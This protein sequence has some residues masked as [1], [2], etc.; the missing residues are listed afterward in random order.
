[1][2]SRSGT[3]AFRTWTS[4][5]TCSKCP[6]RRTGFPTPQVSLIFTYLRY[7]AQ[8]INLVCLAPEPE[9]PSGEPIAVTTP[10]ESVTT[11]AETASAV[12]KRR[13]AKGKAPATTSTEPAY[14]TRGAKRR[15][16]EDP[17]EDVDM[18]DVT[19]RKAD[20]PDV[21]YVLVDGPS[22]PR[23]TQR[24]R[25]DAG[26]VA[27][28]TVSCISHHSYHANMVIIFSGDVW[29]LPGQFTCGR[30]PAPIRVQTGHHSL[31]KLCPPAEEMRPRSCLGTAHLA[32]GRR[33]Q[34]PKHV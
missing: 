17:T 34:R 9:E 24:A 5:S 18:G 31:R 27:Y 12:A 8:L 20:L 19:P 25:K 4:Q 2:V 23:P 13:A 16:E 6:L 3:T 33:N 30:V 26:T 1:M 28:G 15:A 32:C 21:P 10:A 29:P 11:P 7:E 14:A 22:P